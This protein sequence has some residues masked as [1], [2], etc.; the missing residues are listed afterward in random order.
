[1]LFAS[2]NFVFSNCT[3]TTAAELSAIAIPFTGPEI[4]A[5]PFAWFSRDWG[6]WSINPERERPIQSKSIQSMSVVIHLKMIKLL[7]VFLS[8]AEARHRYFKENEPC[9]IP[10]FDL[11]FEEVL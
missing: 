10:E 9:Y 5:K 1:M 3:W 6:K 11:G 2:K 7:L 4:N 8:L